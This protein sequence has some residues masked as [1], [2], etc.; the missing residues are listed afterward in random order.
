M[1]TIRYFGPFRDVTK[2]M[3]EEVPGG[4]S[5]RY[6]LS[7]LESRY[8]KTFSPSEKPLPVAGRLILL[9]NGRHVQHL[10]G[11]DTHLD[12]GDVLSVF[13]LLGGG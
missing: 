2:T 5:V 8:G 10:D 1:V 4:Q 6:L 7:V 11:L 3:E 12:D 9:V 13:P